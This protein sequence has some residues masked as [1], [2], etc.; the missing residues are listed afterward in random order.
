MNELLLNKI[1]SKRKEDIYP[2]NYYSPFETY[3]CKQRLLHILDHLR[4]SN[5]KPQ[6]VTALS[7]IYNPWS[8]MKSAAIPLGKATT[9]PE[10]R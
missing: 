8:M 5:I 10:S 1:S 6:H 9:C 7:F 3:I 2:Y 4:V